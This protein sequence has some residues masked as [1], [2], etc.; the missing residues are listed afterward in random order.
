MT[1]LPGVVLPLSNGHCVGRRADEAVETPKLSM[2]VE[3][4]IGGA[5]SEDPPDRLYDYGPRVRKRL[6]F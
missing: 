4:R 3:A 2:W 5:D 6:F 1:Y